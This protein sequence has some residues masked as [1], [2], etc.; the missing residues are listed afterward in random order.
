MKVI[1]Q[2]EN[3]K[4]AVLAVERAVG[5]N[6]SLPILNNILLKTENGRLKVAGTNLEMGITYFLGAKIDDIGEIAVPAR[7]FVDFL[8]NSS[9]EKL[10]LTGKNNILVI[11]SGQNKTQ[12]LGYVATDFPIIPKIKE[13]EI[14]TMPAPQLHEAFSSVVDSTAVTETRPELAG[15]AMQFDVEK[16]VFAATDSFRLAEKVVHTK[17]AQKKTIIVPRATAAE[18]MR[19]TADEDGDVKIFVNDSQMACLVGDA[20]IV[21]R[22]I[23]GAYPEYQKVIPDKFVSQ[24]VADRAELE[25]NAR[26][27]GLF[28]SQISDVVLFCDKETLQIIARSSDKG[29]TQTTMKAGVKNG[30]FELAIN[31]RYLL[32]GLRHV[33]TKMVVIDFTGV[34]SP[35]ILRPEG[36]ARD[37]TYLIMPI[38][39]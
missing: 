25:R 27:A 17:A 14:C 21:S 2:Y 12:I 39:T 8:Q 13:K 37:Y 35:L 19:V 36:G 10:T 3:L 38:R 33:H 34:G 20:E 7:I 18:M 31:H 24:V 9:G 23:D 30:S 32:D 28:S 5:K 16:I 11:S 26:L 6:I 15:V 29:E 22:L 1:V 4:R